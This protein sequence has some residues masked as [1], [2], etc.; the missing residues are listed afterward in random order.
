MLAFVI[1]AIWTVSIIQRGGYHNAFL[2]FEYTYLK[3]AV[4]IWVLVI[5]RLA[6]F[7]DMRVL[8][9]TII[10]VWSSRIP[11]VEWPTK[12]LFCDI[13]NIILQL[14]QGSFSSRPVHAVTVLV[15][16]NLFLANIKFVPKYY[17]TQSLNGQNVGIA[18]TSHSSRVSKTFLFL[19]WALTHSSFLYSYP[20]VANKCRLEY[21]RDSISNTV[22]RVVSYRFVRGF[23]HRRVK[24][25]AFYA[26]TRALIRYRAHD[27][28]LP[29]TKWIVRR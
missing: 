6:Q 1:K 26:L 18:R 19:I 27:A 21:I 12:F 9:K 2:K 20:I 10:R 13:F 17:L 5:T 29:R 14:V 8:F 16:L 15:I 4:A 23:D 3:I 28:G 22:S 24:S 25:T 7:A 11:T